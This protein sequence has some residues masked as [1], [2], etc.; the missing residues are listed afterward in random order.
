[1]VEAE[2]SDCAPQIGPGVVNAAELFDHSA[3]D[4][5]EVAGIIWDT[6]FGEEIDQ[7]IKDFARERPLPGLEPRDPGS[8][9]DVVA[10]APLFQELDDQIGGILQVAVPGISGRQ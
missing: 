6:V 4:Q 3:A 7:T 2:R 5:A 8:V 10:F 1:L 9:D